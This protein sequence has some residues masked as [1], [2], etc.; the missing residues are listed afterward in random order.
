M[1]RLPNITPFQS[2]VALIDKSSH[3]LGKVILSL[4]HQRQPR[5]RVAQP[6]VLLQASGKVGEKRDRRLFERRGHLPF[7]GSGVA[8]SRREDHT[9]IRGQSLARQIDGF[10]IRAHG[11]RNTGKQCGRVRRDGHLS[12]EKHRRLQ[13]QRQGAASFESQ[14]GWRFL[15]LHGRV[16]RHQATR[17]MGQNSEQVQVELWSHTETVHGDLPLTQAGQQRPQLRSF[18]QIGGTHPIADVRDVGRSIRRSGLQ[19]GFKN[20][21]QV[22]RAERHPYLE[23]LQSRFHFTAAW[24]ME[25][26]V[27]SLSLDINREQADAIRFRQRLKQCVQHRKT[28]LA[29]GTHLAGRGV[30]QD[31]MVASDHTLRQL[32]GLQYD[33]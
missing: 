5:E 3:T 16:E 4:V 31:H 1:S 26:V 21:P 14:L 33:R 9:R 30:D 12:R 10:A 25:A 2:R 22:R 8:R 11:Q 32:T 28:V 20:R 18:N 29:V 19:R 17:L 23:C 7:Q 24:S 13:G 15:R 27:E 6:T